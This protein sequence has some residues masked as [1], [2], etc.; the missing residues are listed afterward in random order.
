MA[1]KR[2]TQ[3]R[4]VCA[5]PFGAALAKAIPLLL[6][7]LPFT[8]IVVADQPVPVV[9][10]SK[11]ATKKAPSLQ[12]GIDRL[13]S[14]Y[15]K[16][17][18]AVVGVS[19]VSLPGGK[20]TAAVRADRQF[21]PASNQ[22][23]LT[24]AFALAKLGGQFRFTTRVYLSGGDII[25][26]GGYDPLPG[27]PRLA[28]V[29]GKSIYHE[30]DRWAAAMKIKLGK[31][32]KG[33]LIVSALTDRR[34]YRHED[35]P[36]SQH[37]RWYAAPV[38]PLN[39]HDNCFD[40]TFAVRDGKV[41]PNVQPESRLIRIV[42]RLRLDSRHVW[43]LGSRAD[44]SVV[45]LRGKVSTSTRDPY[46]VAVN[47]PPL[48]LG[49]VLVDRL[50]KA[51]V[52]F[53][54]RVRAEE[55]QKARLA[56]AEIICKT[57]T[58]LSAVMKR[59]FKRSLNLAA[60]CMMLRAGD[61]TWS[62]SAKIM[63]ETLV[64]TFGLAEAQL[65]VRDGGGL[66]RKNRISPAAVTKLL[67]AMSKHKHA[68]IFAESLPISGTDGTLRSRLRSRPYR[69]RVLAKTGYL[70]GASCLSGYVLDAD[71]RRAFAFS[72]LVNKIRGRSGGAKRLQDDI[73]RMLV[74]APEVK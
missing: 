1:G 25:V 31:T 27:D 71:G 50:E 17:S 34:A 36:K 52:A 10:D 68:D 30:L 22:K 5:G 44:D 46:S 65:V 66:S 26:E 6:A 15:E 69:G 41:I 57:H 21:V 32:F 47:D 56:K 39:F 28:K 37:Q 8:A 43:S 73:C 7:V 45:T 42:N 70:A 9:P 54:G 63:T 4:F 64:R 23:L 35:W 16:A 51:G 12:D 58:P 62:G 2:N 20:A 74:D 38:A 11:P 55:I 24:G 60:E 72:V 40:V 67:A 3:N 49:R 33:A 13:V 14:E 18:G 59:A 53:T 61:G 48:L 19:V 29:A